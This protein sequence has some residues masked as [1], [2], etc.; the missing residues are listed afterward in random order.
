MNYVPLYIKTN[1]NLLNS[2]IKLDELI[3]LA[4]KYNFHALTITDNNM[5]GV[6]DFYYLCLK[7]N[8]KPIIGLEIKLDDKIIV[9]Y[10]KNYHGYQNL[11]KLTTIMSSGNLTIDDI[12]KLNQDLICIVPFKS[13]NIYNDL[14]KIFQDIFV[15]YSTKEELDNLNY[16]NLIYMKEVLYLEEKDK[17]YYPYLTCIKD[18][19]TINEIDPHI[20]N[21]QLDTYE[22]VLENFKEHLNNNYKIFDMCNL[23]LPKLEGLL[24]IYECPNGLDSYTYLKQLCKEGLKRIFGQTVNE[25]YITRL[26]Y[27]L[28]VINSMGFCDYF[29]VVCDYVKYA[30]EKGILV[31]PGRGSA[32]GSLV[33]YCL[34]ITTIDPLKYNLMFER[35]LNPERVTMPDIDID[36][37]DDKREEVIEYCINKYGIKKVAPIITF[38]TLKTKQVIRDVARVMN[39]DLKQVD[40]MSKLLEANI[41]LGQNLKNEKVQKYLEFNKEFAKCYKIAMKLE[42]LKRHSSVHAAGIVMSNQN[43]DNI[44]PLDKHVNEYLTGFDMTY[45]E[46]IGLLKMDFLGLKNLTLIDNILKDLNNDLTFDSIPLNDSKVLSI[47]TKAN[48]IGIFQFESSGMINFLRKF[49]PNTFEDIIAS[50]ALFRPGPMKNIDSYIKRKRGLEKIEYLDPSLENILKPTY[51]IIVYQEQI[52][53][54][55]HIMADYSLGEADI[56]RRAMSKKKEEVLLKEKDKFISRSVKKGYS[57]VVATKVYNMILKFA[58]YGFNRAHS[59]AYSVIAYKMAYLKYYY[60]NI[61]L[62]NVLTNVMGSGSE[63]KKYIYEAKLNNIKILSPNINL[64]TK[65]YEVTEEGIIYPLTGIKNVGITAIKTI[66]EERNKSS[67]KDIFDFTKRTY[68]KSINRKTLESLITAGC[69]DCFNLNK[70]TLHTNLDSIINYSEIGELIDEESLKPIIKEYEEYTD[71]EL[72]NKEFEIFGFY[73]NNHPVTKYKFKYP[74]VSINQL[75]DY[76]DKQVDVVIYVDKIKKITTKK[77]DSMCFITGSDEISNLDIVIFPKIYKKYENIKV[78][79]ILLINGKVEKRFDKIQLVVNKVKVLID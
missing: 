35:F 78:G 55:A 60:P 32:A 47:F 56:L 25:A 37:A 36:F 30:K 13:L 72:L 75:E 53:Q 22:Y 52:M 59:V 27:E 11:C 62:K 18:G 48:T 70:K 10:C 69:F 68:G 57:E 19:I 54:I 79:D 26:K 77:N 9:L 73:L 43:L 38:G 64:S 40:S 31:G 24:P 63:T 45:L 15:S 28:N 76:F 58:S 7:N 3:N 17:D 21:N 74:S 66:I 67:Y 34:N 50:I 51:G 6:L 5:Y 41:T 61:F 49:K 20:Y 16:S 42:G 1:N 46:Q 23:I 8:I 12:K 4:K 65:N 44:I 2:M 14:N 39:I 33:S 71:Q 29:L